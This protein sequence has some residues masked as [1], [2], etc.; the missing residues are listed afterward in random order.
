[1]KKTQK[2]VLISIKLEYAKKI[3]LGVKRYEYRKQSIHQDTS[4]ILLYVTSPIMRIVGIAE[5]KSIHEGD[6]STLWEQT[7]HAGGV[8]R[9]FYREYFL[10][11][12]KAFAIELDQIIPLNYWVN[13]K[14]IVMT[15]Y[16]PQS[17]KYV[18][19]D[20][21]NDV[22]GRGMKESVSSH[23][24]FF[25]GIHG[26]GKSTFC[27]RLKRD[28]DID[29]ISASTII[30]SGDKKSQKS[31][32]QV[33]DLN[34][35]Q[36]LLLAG[37]KEKSLKGDFLLDGHF[38]LLTKQNKIEKIPLEVFRDINPREL[39][40]LE[41]TPLMVYKNLKARDGIKY[42][43]RTIKKMLNVE[44]THARY[45]AK[46]LGVP[47]AIITRKDYLQVRDKLEIHRKTHKSD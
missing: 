25:G 23:I 36:E 41:D 35:N 4:H 40:L 38:C 27:N 18:N 9:K 29:T 10:K 15:F 45:I 39:F 1:M 22:I 21:Y 42:D 17:F 32:K 34:R 30:K 47:L 13:P 3:L 26:V 16:P 14:D 37:L 6:P 28:I 11:K 44:S 19:S 43:I 12:T 46:H 31:N 5:V 20:F 2:I 24:L 7:K 8:T 33:I